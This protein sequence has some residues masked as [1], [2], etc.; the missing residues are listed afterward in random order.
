MENKDIKIDKGSLE[1]GYVWAPYVCVTVATSIN[2]E[3]VWYKN[4][5]K[6]FLLKIKHFFI[7]PKYLKSKFISKY[8]QKTINSNF[9]NTIKITDGNK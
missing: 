9:Y 7:K 5:F 2:G 4:K 1:K 6:N 8:S 3:T